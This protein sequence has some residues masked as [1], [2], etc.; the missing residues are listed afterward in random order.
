[1]LS[2]SEAR[3]GQT[4]EHEMEVTVSDEWAR[5]LCG[6][7]GSPG[8]DETVR[9][10]Q[11]AVARNL[12]IGDPQQVSVEQLR[13]SLDC[14]A[15]DQAQFHDND[16]DGNEVYLDITDEYAHQLCDENSVA[17]AQFKRAFQMQIA[18]SINDA[19]NPATLPQG[20]QACPDPDGP[21]Y[22]TPEQV[23]VDNDSILDTAHC[24][25]RQLPTGIGV[26]PASPTSGGS[27]APSVQEVDDAACDDTCRC[28]EQQ[29]CGA[30][31]G[32]CDEA[33]A[34]SSQI[35]QGGYDKARGCGAG[36]CCAPHTDGSDCIAE[37]YATCQRASIDQQSSPA[38]EAHAP[39]FAKYI[40]YSYFVV[41]YLY[42]KG[43]L[44]AIEGEV[45]QQQVRAAQRKRMDIKAYRVHRRVHIAC[46]NLAVVFVLI[47]L[48]PAP[49]R[50]PVP[51]PVLLA[52]A[53]NQFAP[54]KFRP[55]W[56][57]LLHISPVIVEPTGTTQQIEP[58]DRRAVAAVVTATPVRV[59]ASNVPTVEVA[60]NDEHSGMLKKLGGKNKDTWQDVNASIGSSGMAW[61][62]GSNVRD[63][64]SGSQR[65][66][67]SAQILSVSIWS[68]I[69]IEHGFEVVSSVKNGKVYKFCAGDEAERDRW[70][71]AIE[72]AICGVSDAHDPIIVQSDLTVTSF[73]HS[74]QTVTAVEDGGYDYAAALPEQAFASEPAPEPA[75][76]DPTISTSN[77]LSPGRLDVENPAIMN[78]NEV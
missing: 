16:I 27:N 4:V 26:Q 62:F 68:D 60:I 64:L 17:F 20:H 70:M 13:S 5:T 44:P 66:L 10:I 43:K 74:M 71:S 46:A 78:E 56:H 1:M 59:A 31:N 57:R 30:N 77:P 53:V 51:I 69:G 28:T 52:A 2:D 72:L 8:Y 19:C 15:A 55:I 7:V 12:G 34:L 75:S 76:D 50:W 9:L 37:G 3:P 21:G 6:G 39:S 54:E 22:I 38:E 25:P 48:I 35:A 73:I 36:H 32:V 40:Y 63:T 23:Q 11:S 65:V 24:M 67:P 14:D 61:S 41:G 45:T 18:A 33:A 47:S 29:G 58:S 49:W 42:V